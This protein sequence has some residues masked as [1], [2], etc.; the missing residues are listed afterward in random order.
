MS[1]DPI[2]DGDLE[3]KLRAA[4][5]PV[6]PGPGFV[7]G[8]MARIAAE[9]PRATRPLRIRA[10]ASWG[11]FALAASIVLAVLVAHQQ[12]ARRTEQGLE[13]R[14]QLIQALRVTGDKL[15]LASRMVNAPPP[16]PNTDSGA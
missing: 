12:Q 8:V 16:P 1:H 6:D 10:V 4:L 9:P 11:G 3:L 14:R 7:G 2:N 5:K 13:A 15:D